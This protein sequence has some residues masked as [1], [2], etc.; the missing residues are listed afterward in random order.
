LANNPHDA[1]L[2]L[3][4]IGCQRLIATLENELGQVSDPIG[5]I[6]SLRVK[7]G[8][9]SREL[10]SAPR[11]QMVDALLAAD[12]GWMELERGDLESAMTKFEAAETSAAA[13]VRQYPDDQMHQDQLRTIRN[14]LAQAC[15]RL[16]QYERATKL[17]RQLIERSRKDIQQYPNNVLL[18]QR[19]ATEL[20]S[21]GD[22]LSLAGDQLKGLEA[23]REAEKIRRQL[24]DKD[25]R[26]ARLERD[27][28]VC[29]E[30]IA[31]ILL[32]RKNVDEAIVVLDEAIQRHSA[33]TAN[34]PLNLD[35][36]QMDW[37]LKNLSAAAA[38]KQG[39]I[40]DSLRLLNEALAIEQALVRDD[41]SRVDDWFGIAETCHQLATTLLS[42]PVEQQTD[43][44]LQHALRY[45]DQSLR[46]LR[47]IE[48]RG[49]LT[50]AQTNRKE[51]AER[52]RQLVASAIQALEELSID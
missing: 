12:L 52:T 1:E 24:L 28:I 8:E 37:I 46:A 6:E 21:E 31:G 36:K 32:S 38:V 5:R 22:L 10:A 27:L 50:A 40:D 35:L 42:R 14:H 7:L 33:V 15:E 34:N 47:E 17:V 11:A 48:S 30:R 3:A 23:F 45:T 18:Q 44:D 43:D 16:G 39:R 13:I 41:A 49:R 51:A 26:N 29:L 20:V 25:P 9:I 4:Q 19:L 2:K